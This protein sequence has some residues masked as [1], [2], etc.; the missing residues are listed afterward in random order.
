VGED[1]SADQAGHN[2]EKRGNDQS[3]AGPADGGQAPH[4]ATFPA[5]GRQ[6][7]DPAGNFLVEAPDLD[8][9]VWIGRMIPVIDGWGEV[10]P[11]LTS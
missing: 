11:V 9:T 5:Y 1:H 3:D 10:R 7:G 4:G 8:H 2:V 6:R